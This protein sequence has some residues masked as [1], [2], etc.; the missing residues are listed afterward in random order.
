[1]SDPIYAKG[2]SQD[3]YHNVLTA[4]R[5]TGGYEVHVLNTGEANGLTAKVEAAPA[6]DDNP[7][8]PLWDDAVVVYGPANTAGDAVGVCDVTAA[9]AEASGLH[10]YRIAVR[11]QATGASTS[12]V[13]VS[14]DAKE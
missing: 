12:F 1:M 4:H 11:S 13:V 2:A 7:D 8:V 10:H 3:V 6:D 14:Q 9:A 5:R